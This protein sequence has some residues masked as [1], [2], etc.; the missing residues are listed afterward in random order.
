MIVGAILGVTV[1]SPRRPPVFVL[2]L[3][4]LCASV[5]GIGLVT[6]AMAGASQG[7]AIVSA[8]AS[9]VGVTYC[10]ASTNFSLPA[11]V[12]EPVR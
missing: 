3:T 5:L 11:S 1:R 7:Q 2:L 4:L 10:F 12:S 9:Q 6:P 8:A